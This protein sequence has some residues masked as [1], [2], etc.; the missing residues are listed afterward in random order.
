MG[1]I[2]PDTGDHYWYTRFA[3][4]SVNPASVS[5]RFRVDF[6]YLT[7]QEVEEM[8][9]EV[10]INEWRVA[11]EGIRFDPKLGIGCPHRI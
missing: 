1:L 10:Q 2:N 4:G 11:L 7:C 9:G 6:L 5:G 8:Q 3:I